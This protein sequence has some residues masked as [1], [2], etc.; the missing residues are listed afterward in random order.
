MIVMVEDIEKIVDEFLDISEKQLTSMEEKIKKCDI[1][2]I[3]NDYALIS[4]NLQNAS[5]LIPDLSEFV[6]MH[7]MM[8]VHKIHDKK[9]ELVKTI[10]EHCKF[11]TK[12]PF[13]YVKKP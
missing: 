13:R 2:G 10:P 9:H 12:E 3:F 6:R 11:E 1:I 5:N 8:E 4:V 7:K